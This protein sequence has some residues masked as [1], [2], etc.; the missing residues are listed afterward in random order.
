MGIGFLGGVVLLG[1]VLWECT[2]PKKPEKASFEFPSVMKD[3]VKKDFMR[4]CVKGEV[5]Y[6]LHCSKCHNVK[7]G[8][9][10]VIPD[11]TSA[12]VNGYDMRMANREH[13][14]NLQGTQ[15][16]TEEL[17]YII[18]FLSYKTK[19]GVPAIGDNLPKE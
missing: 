13:Q 5:L 4:Q 15:V 3:Y 9:K 1:V 6:D 11:F 14:T 17:G 18:S 2:T 10:V 8:R 12:Q 16:T 19:S 7:V